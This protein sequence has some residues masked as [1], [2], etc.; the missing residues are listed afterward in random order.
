MNALHIPRI[1]SIG[2]GSGQSQLIRALR[3]FN[4]TLTAIVAMADDGGSTG[5]L[6]QQ[7][8]SIPPGDIRNCLVALAQDPTSALVRS[9][10]R[11]LPFASNHA[12]G[13]LL[14]AILADES[15]SFMEAIHVCENM[16]HC[17]GKVVPSTLDNVLLRGKTLDGRVI[18]GEDFIGHGPCTLDRVWLE[19]ASPT[20][21]PEAVAAIKQADL[22]VLGPGSLFTSIIPNLLVPGILEALHSCTA[23]CVFVCPKADEQYES[24]GLAADEYVQA[25]INHGLSGCIDAV[26]LHKTKESVGAATVSFRA[27]TQEQIT[28]HSL[29]FSA[30]NAR[31]VRVDAPIVEHI[32]SHI[33]TVVVR[34]FDLPGMPSVHNPHKLADALRGVCPVPLEEVTH[35]I[36]SRS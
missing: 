35:V 13:N 20:A 32:E 31:P 27:L 8:S 34:D 18:C 17:V 16:F 5:L 10:Q 15:N 2:G 1:V 22:V 24:W 30:Q 26:L 6:R 9:F 7:M 36:Y 3:Q 28:A 33:P 23:R 25:L 14:L 11:R 29:G 19:P 12:L 4:C 21:C